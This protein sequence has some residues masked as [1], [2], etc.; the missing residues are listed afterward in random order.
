MSVQLQVALIV[1]TILLFLYLIG[2]VRKGK[3]RTDYAVGWI[4]SSIAL[5]IVAI[6]PQIANFGAKL[7]GVIST[8]NIVFAFIIML[9]IIL[10]Y[11]LFEKVSI[12]EEK[13]KN[14]IQEIGILKEKN[15]LKG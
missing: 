8:A 7:L 6:F 5:I 3:L 12:L 4:F 15:N 1:L 14:L 13:Q 11:V 9:L 10:V 2:N